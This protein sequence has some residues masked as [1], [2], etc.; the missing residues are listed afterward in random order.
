MTEGIL[1]NFK[2]KNQKV[3]LQIDFTQKYHLKI[4]SRQKL[5]NSVMT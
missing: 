1:G 5:E 4:L 3:E 2:A